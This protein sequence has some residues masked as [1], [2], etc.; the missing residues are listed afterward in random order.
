MAGDLAAYHRGA[1]PNPTSDTNPGTNHLQARDNR[2]TIPNT[3]RQTTAHN[4]P[5]QH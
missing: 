5:Q 2:H 3:A 4:R 1:T